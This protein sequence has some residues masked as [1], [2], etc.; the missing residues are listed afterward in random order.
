MATCQVTDKELQAYRAYPDRFFGRKLEPSRRA[1]D[2]VE[3]F[4]FFYATY[5]HTPRERLLEFLKDASD[6]DELT[7]LSQRDL[8][9][10]CC[11]RWT[12]SAVSEQQ[13]R[14][15]AETSEMGPSGSSEASS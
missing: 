14:K 7:T 15:T 4:D 13:R 6:F 1:E 3:L 2:A 11:E 12:W 8:A 5:Q 10:E 9:I